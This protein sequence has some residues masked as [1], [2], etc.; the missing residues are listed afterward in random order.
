[1]RLSHLQ[2]IQQV[3]LPLLA[4]ALR[5]LP[6][7]QC[8]H[9]IIVAQSLEN[10]SFDAVVLCTLVSLFIHNLDAGLEHVFCLLELLELR[11]DVG[12]INQHLCVLRGAGAVDP[13]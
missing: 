4:V 13:K 10:L 12:G 5:L 11:L 8:L 1:M 3:L 6:A 2:A 9:P 7:L